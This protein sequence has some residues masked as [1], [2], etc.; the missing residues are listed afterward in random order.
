MWLRDFP[1][2]AKADILPAL[3][4]KPVFAFLAFTSGSYEGAI[5]KDLRLANS[6]HRRGF[7]VHVYWLMESNRDLVADGINQRVLSRGSRYLLNRPSRLLDAM[8]I[9]GRLWTPARRRR[10]MQE[11]RNLTLRMLTNFVVSMCDGCND[12][13]LVRRLK[14]ML[15]I[16][17]VTHVLPTFAMCCPI[18]LA[19]KESGGCDVDF[20]P[21]FQGEE[22]FANYANRA[23]RIDDYYRQLRRCVDAS[24]FQA[25]SVSDDYADRVHEEMGIPREKIVTIYPGIELPPDGDKPPMD[26]LLEKLPGIKKDV[27][28]VAYFGRQDAEKGIDLLLYAVKQLRNKGIDLQLICCGG[29]SFG[30]DY[31][32]V[33]EEIAKHLRIEVMW[34]R[35]VSDALRTALY[36]HARCVVCPSIHREPFGMVAPEAMSYG[37]PVLV[38]DHGGIVE[39]IH[40]NGQAGGLTFKAWDSGDLAVQLERLLTDDRLHAQLAA[41]AKTVAAQFSVDALTDRMLKHLGIVG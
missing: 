27:P 22:I 21:M 41:N 8:G 5:I 13:S 31:R 40:C 19:A 35:S 6:L 9:I 30:L 1:A 29:T 32:Q 25:A 23:G 36:A 4:T 7:K 2:G 33:C 28:I 15:K 17:G 11:H 26:A 16:D 18:V 38:P 34:K 39:S 20:L 3:M 37:T 14:N 24:K 12:P 10:W